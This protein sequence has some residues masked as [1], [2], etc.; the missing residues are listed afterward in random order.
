MAREKT[1]RTPKAG[2]SEAEVADVSGEPS[3]NPE[4]RPRD[5]ALDPAPP[6]EPPGHRTPVEVDAGSGGSTIRAPGPVPGKS[7]PRPPT[8][9]A[10]RARAR[11]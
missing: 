2:H 8:S 4:L 7:G 1:T 10:T 5:G 3:A 6:S 9:S 11:S